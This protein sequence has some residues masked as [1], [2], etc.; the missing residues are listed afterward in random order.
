MELSSAL[1]L[2]FCL[3]AG[4]VYILTR[5]TRD[6]TADEN[7]SRTDDTGEQSQEEGQQTE[8]QNDSSIGNDTTRNTYSIEEENDFDYELFESLKEWR[9]QVASDESVRKR[10]VFGDAALEKIAEYKPSDKSSLRYTKGVG[11]RRANEYG[12]GI[13]SLIPDRDPRRQKRRW[14]TVKDILESE[15]I[16]KFYHFTDRSNLPSIRLNGGLYSWYYC[17]NNDIEIPRPGG[18]Q[19]SRNLDRENEL[20]DYVRLSFVESHPMCHVAKREGRI[21]NPVILEISPEVA[22]WESTRFSDRNAIDNRA[23]IGCRPQDLSRI[24]FDILRQSRWS[25][26]SEK[27]YWQAEVLVKTHVPLRYMSNYL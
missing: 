10:T 5:S 15:D 18:N 26:E 7:Q 9:D 1:L 21:Q 14:E 27:H 16:N 17:E 2:G 8:V 3:L 11:P 22:L 13:L 24:R 20:E 19:V 12:E 4:L 23:R 6:R 25:N